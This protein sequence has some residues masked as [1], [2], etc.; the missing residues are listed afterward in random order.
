MGISV[1]QAVPG[2][3]RPFE[4]MWRG[5]RR[6]E[7]QQM[8]DILANYEDRHGIRFE[9]VKVGTAGWIVKREGHVP[10]R[11]PGIIVN[12]DVDD[13]LLQT[14]QIKGIRR[15]RYAEFLQR[16][17]PPIRIGSSTSDALMDATYAIAQDIVGHGSYLTDNHASLLAEVTDRL[18]RAQAEGRAQEEAAALQSNLDRIRTHGF[19]PT[20]PFVNPRHAPRTLLALQEMF[21]E[22][23]AE[24][25]LF[26]NTVKA[27]EELCRR[28]D[29][30]ESMNV[31]LFTLGDPPEQ[32]IKYLKLLA[33]NPRMQV[34]HVFI[35]GVSKDE[36]LEQLI[37]TQS[38][39][40]LAH[41]KGRSDGYFLGAYE[42]TVIDLDDSRQSLNA[43]I[44]AMRS[45]AP[46]IGAEWRS[47]RLRRKGTK[48]GEKD[49][50]EQGE[51]DEMRVDTMSGI[52][53]AERI[54]DVANRPRRRGRVPSPRRG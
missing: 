13:T 40:R 10:Q 22:T 21:T 15:A 48:D 33:Y 32:L 47:V 17:I 31:D 18:Q 30:G 20:D 5:P 41:N 38:M 25:P 16:Q 7:A 24:I 39:G 37:T 26:P 46:H 36:F 3:G 49:W 28:R 2:R 9:L 43:K 34:D 53:L 54:M 50:D 14:T 8:R 11:K 23:L 4:G 27:L 29:A 19:E 42:H 35:T 12:C 6:T 51:H 44:R 52:T 1:E 45:L